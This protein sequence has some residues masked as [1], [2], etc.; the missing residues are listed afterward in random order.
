MS[1]SKLFTTYKTIVRKEMIRI[2]RIWSQTLLPPVITQSLYFLIF[3]GFVGSRISGDFNGQKYI[4]F[5]VPGLVMMAVITASFSNV[6]GSFFGSK[7]QRNIEEILVSPTPNWIIIA[8]FITGG[9]VRG[10]LVGFIVFLVGYVF[11]GVTIL[12]P[13]I[14]LIFVFLTAV[15]FSLGGL[16]N[17]IFATKFDDIS[18]FPTFV[19]TPLTYLGGVFYSINQLPPAWQSISKINPIVYMIDGFRYGFSGRSDLNVGY[20][21]VMLMLFTIGFWYIAWYLLKKGIGLKS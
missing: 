13:L 14:T 12:H 20:S 4:E 1:P 7:F 10:L 8:G 3:G 9:I 21:F 5:I 6:V 11:T 19:L 17:A 16:I 15:V 18:I 2:F